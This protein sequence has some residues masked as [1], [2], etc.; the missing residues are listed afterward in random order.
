[1]GAVFSLLFIVG[2]FD[3]STAVLIWYLWP[4]LYGRNPLIGNPSLPFVGWL[5]FAYA[6]IPPH[7]SRVRLRMNSRNGGSWQLPANLYV[8][9]TGGMW[10]LAASVL[11]L[12]PRALRNF[13]Y[14]VLAANRKAVFGTTQETCP[15]VPPEWRKRFR[16]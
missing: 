6:L 11:K 14:D 4:C 5:L 1:M 13:D 15:L 10:F 3:R 9:Q 16:D 12:L 7:S 2:R 8:E